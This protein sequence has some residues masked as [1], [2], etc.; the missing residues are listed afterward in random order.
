VKV[1]YDP[2][3]PRN[4]RI[5]RGRWNL[6]IPLLVSAVGALLCSLGVWSASRRRSAGA[7]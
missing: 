4:A 6:A 1:L 5:D 7:S 2:D 3:G